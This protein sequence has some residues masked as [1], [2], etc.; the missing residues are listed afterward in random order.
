MTLVQLAQ[1]TGVTVAD[2]SVLKNGRARVVRYSTLTAVRDALGCQPGDLL[3]VEPAADAPPGVRRAVSLR[4][5]G[6]HG[7]LRTARS[8]RDG[9]RPPQGPGPHPRT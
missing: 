3:V 9:D 7:S 1:A 8:G 4:V 5:P 6:L 2:L